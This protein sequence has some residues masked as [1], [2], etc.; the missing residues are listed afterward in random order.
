M[1][2]ITEL[3]KAGKLTE[4]YAMAK[5]K[6]EENFDEHSAKD[7]FWVL[8]DMIKES[9]QKRNGTDTALLYTMREMYNAIP[10]HDEVLRE[11]YAWAIY[12]ILADNFETIGSRVARS[13]LAEY[14]ALNQPRPTRLHSC[15]LNIA[16]RMAA[17]YPDFKFVP[18]LKIWDMNN[19]MPEDR[20]TFKG[21]DGR[22]YTSLYE[23]VAKAYA[24]TRFYNPDLKI[25]GPEHDE[26]MKIAADRGFIPP[27]TMV[28]TK[29]FSAEVRGRKMHFVKLV[30]PEG[31]EASCE[32]HT[33]TRLS[34]IRYR[35]IPGV[36]FDILPR[37][38]HKSEEM[39][40]E[41]ARISAR[42]L[43]EVFEEAVGYVE[44][45]DI[46]HHHIHIFDNFSRHMVCPIDTPVSVGTFV[47]IAPVVPQRDKF[48][49]AFINSIFSDK[50]AG[51]AAFGY[52]KAHI[53]Y[54]DNEK[55]YCSW[56]LDEGEEPISERGGDG[57]AYDKGYLSQQLL[58]SKG[59][60]MPAVGT[61]IGII[62]FLKRGRDGSKHPYV[63]DFVTA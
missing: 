9:R 25:E 31:K 35:D 34:P 2:E 28:A 46:S 15:I 24:Y 29:V 17:L 23:H 39:R 10:E 45:I 50:A 32:V 47:R 3:R 33:I 53:T 26:L 49:V 19:I 30:S 37:L 43:N 44:H 18:F 60:S 42:H 58:Q 14:F 8:A 12:Y 54:T 5:E 57:S 52:R 13:M 38:S 20:V 62:V 6:I 16:T 22:N 7:M 48:K 11:G 41:A 59:N 40:V 27:M 21:E 36:L 61:S 1:S 56:A 4:A 63:V 51:A 55:G